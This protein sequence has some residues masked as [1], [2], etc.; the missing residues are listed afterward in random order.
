MHKIIIIILCLLPASLFAQGYRVSG[1]VIDAQTRQPLAGASVFCQNTTIGT[2]TNSNGEFSMTVPAGGYDIIVSFTGYETQSESVTAQSENLS[3]LRFVLKEKSKSM[4][5]VSVVATTEVKNGWEKYGE[6][7]R[8]QFIG[9]TENS[10]LCTIDNPSALRFFFSKKRNRLKVLASEDLIITNKALGYKIRYT[11]DS[12]TYEYASGLTQFTGYPL[13]EPLVGNAEEVEKWK[14]K[15]EEAY[16]GSMTH[17]MKGY[18]HKTLGQDG[19]KIELLDE[20]TKKFRSLN[21]P[22]DTAFATLADGDLELHPS[23]ILRIIYL[24]ET[25]EQDYLV[26]N[27]LALNNTVQISQLTFRDAILVEQNGYCY[28][29]KDILSIGYWA[30][31]KIADLMPYDY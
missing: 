12:F 16:L 24:N 28:D 30:W 26:K 15:R 31:E 23:T 21:D 13:F 3:Q 29:Q 5:E 14:E 27:K 19:Y 11:L 7:F 25:P 17:F 10:K 6:F 18:Y 8:E 9:M 22:Y 4:E 1:T 20:K 2:L